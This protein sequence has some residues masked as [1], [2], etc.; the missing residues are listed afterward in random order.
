MKRRHYVVIGV[1]TV[2]DADAIVVG[3]SPK[4]SRAERM[5][6]EY[7]QRR[8]GKYLCSVWEC[9]PDQFDSGICVVESTL[10]RIADA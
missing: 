10:E 4:R 7:E 6:K 9:I 2:R 8:G 3:C 5:A 1:H